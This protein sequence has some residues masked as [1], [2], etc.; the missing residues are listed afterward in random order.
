MKTMKILLFLF[1]SI[2]CSQSIIVE[3]DSLFYTQYSGD[4]Q[5]LNISITNLNES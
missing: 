1:L 3:P 2:I 5:T 4:T